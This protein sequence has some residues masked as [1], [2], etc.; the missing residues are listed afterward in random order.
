MKNNKGFNSRGFKSI[1]LFILVIA[2]M[3]LIF[4][5]PPFLSPVIKEFNLNEF[6]E[7][8]KQDKISTSTSTPTVIKGEDKII[9]GELKDG[10]KFKVSFL[11]DYD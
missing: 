6:V 7:A 9:E 3:F 4:R 8:V 2:I 10:T 5:N 11:G 1:A